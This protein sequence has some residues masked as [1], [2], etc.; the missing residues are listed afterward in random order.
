MEGKIQADG[1]VSM[2]GSTPYAPVPT[3]VHID[4][5][6]TNGSFEGVTKTTYCEYRT[7]ATK[8]SW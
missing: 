4:G 6:F 3:A 2:S 5:K 7:T 1:T 8:T